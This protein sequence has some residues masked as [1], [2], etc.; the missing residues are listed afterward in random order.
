MPLSGT[1][2]LIQIFA[3]T[4]LPLNVSVDAVSIIKMTM[5]GQLSLF[6]FHHLRLN[7][8]SSMEDLSQ[9]AAVVQKWLQFFSELSCSF[10]NTVGLSTNHCIKN[11]LN[12]IVPFCFDQ[13]YL[14]YAWQKGT[15][16]NGRIFEMLPKF[17][18]QFLTLL[19]T[20]LSC[21]SMQFF[22]RCLE[23]NKL[24]LSYGMNF[25]YDKSQGESK[26][27][28]MSLSYNHVSGW[29]YSKRCSL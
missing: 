26:Q 5:K 6:T 19:E 9:W 4:S 21:C 8:A 14:P 7:S 23:E 16:S 20:T 22:T 17:T 1:Q 10:I 2:Q 18:F 3:C 24:E 28:G 29:H 12:L 15:I 27:E 25:H 13:E 11:N